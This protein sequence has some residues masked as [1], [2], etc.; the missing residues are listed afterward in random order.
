MPRRDRLGLGL[1][2]DDRAAQRHAL[3]ADTHCSW[4]GDQALHFF[5]TAATE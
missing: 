3:I 5:L 4:P 2:G 1:F